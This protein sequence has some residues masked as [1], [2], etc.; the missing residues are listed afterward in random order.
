[1]TEIVK[2]VQTPYIGEWDKGHEKDFKCPY[3]NRYVGT[4][5]RENG[6]I[7]FT[8]TTNVYEIVYARG[9]SKGIKVD[10]NHKNYFGSEECA[11]EY[12]RSGKLNV[13][14]L[15]FVL[16]EDAPVSSKNKRN[17]DTEDEVIESYDDEMDESDDDSYTDSGVDEAELERQRQA[18]AAAEE[19]ERKAREAA[20]AAEKTRKEAVFV[21][22]TETE[23]NVIKEVE[24]VLLEEKIKIVLENFDSI[25]QTAFDEFLP[26]RFWQKSLFITKMDNEAKI[27]EDASPKTLIDFS[28][29]WYEKVEE[30]KK[31]DLFQGYEFSSELV[32]SLLEDKLFKVIEPVIKSTFS[33]EADK[34]VPD[35]VINFRDMVL[36]ENPNTYDLKYSAL[37]NLQK[38]RKEL[39]DA[40]SAF[41]KREEEYKA[42]FELN[43]ELKNKVQGLLNSSKNEV[44]IALLN[45]GKYFYRK[46]DDT[47]LN[48]KRRLAL[49]Y[50][51]EAILPNGY[52]ANNISRVEKTY[53]E[54]AKTAKCT[55]DDKFFFGF[56]NYV[57]KREGF[58][59]LNVLD[60]KASKQ[61]LTFKDRLR[62]LSPFGNFLKAHKIIAVILI[63]LCYGCIS[64]TS[65]A[66]NSKVDSVKS[67]MQKNA[68]EKKALKAKEKK[69]KVV[70]KAR[71]T[72]KQ[73]KQ[74]ENKK[75]SKLKIDLE[76]TIPASELSVT[77]TY[78]NY[79]KITDKGMTLKVDDVTYDILVLFELTATDDIAILLQKE[80]D[81]AFGKGVA[82]TKDW[83]SPSISFGQYKISY[84]QLSEKEIS[85][86]DTAKA[87]LSKIESLNKGESADFT[88]KI[89][90]YYTV[91]EKSTKADIGS[92]K[93]WTKEFLEQS[94]FNLNTHNTYLIKHKT[95]DGNVERKTI[96]LK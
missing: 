85:D 87:V 1:M 78:A 77:G 71:E 96:E 22:L 23:Q 39:L 2:I 60:K 86:P 27:P 74:E 29:K 36:K 40:K 59:I 64:L 88:V 61:N 47:F 24:K 8:G 52:L 55:I 62:L 92:A 11:K 10:M 53:K 18:E 46:D 63:I 42:V 37:K 26:L 5:L 68:K 54:A 44:S 14:F 30:V 43:D 20:E 79:V 76:K 21:S 6:N 51:T 16:A 45:R 91:T 50:L 9:L 15:K 49:L 32:S 7:T 13:D 93:L 84:S 69:S 31:D 57:L 58:E 3:C 12:V 75:A 19:A 67:E 73:A 34:K 89:K 41:E 25:S 94:D 17:H 35:I 80:I 65:K 90:N 38:Y 81:S 4:E 48:L 28:H 70:K 72:E 95:A 83:Q 33:V 56:K 66:V 82:V